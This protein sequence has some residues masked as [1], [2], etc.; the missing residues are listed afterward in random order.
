MTG[1]LTS[2]HPAYIAPSTG[3]K[4]F[5]ILFQGDSITDADRSRLDLTDLG[6]GYARMVGESLEQLYSDTYDF[7]V[8]HKDGKK[9]NRVYSHDVLKIDSIYER[10]KDWAEV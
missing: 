1:G 5:R 6:N 9:E 2:D 3:P 10:L 4:S 7:E 8:K